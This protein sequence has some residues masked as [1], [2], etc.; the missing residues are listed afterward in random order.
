M[1]IAKSN[2]SSQFSSNRVFDKIFKDY[3]AEAYMAKKGG[4]KKDY[5]LYFYGLAF[6]VLFVLAL[7]FDFQIS[8]TITGL[9]NSFLDGIMLV[10]TSSL[11]QIALFCGASIIVFFSNRKKILHL[12]LSAVVSMAV[13]IILKAVIARPRPFTAGISTLE[14]L[15]KS[16]YTTSDFSFPSNHA[17]LAFIPLL[18]LS[19]KWFWPWLAVA[20]LVAFS[21]VYFGL[22]YLSDVIASMSLALLVSY[23]VLRKVK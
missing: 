10:L 2:L 7:Q 3:L 18:F 8:K 23:F 1:N 6:L 13:S 4:N 22:H 15:V 16:A 9:R 11:W 12:W 21:R 14:S 19:K 20:M 5:G 17:I